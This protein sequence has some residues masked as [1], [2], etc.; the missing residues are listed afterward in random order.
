MTTVVNNPAPVAAEKEGNS[1]LIGI[2]IL[3]GFV[4]VLLYFGIPAIKQM[5]PVKVNVPAPQVVIPDKINVNV[6]QD[7]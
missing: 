2:I 3:V 7:K 4:A 6:N 5:G 1:F